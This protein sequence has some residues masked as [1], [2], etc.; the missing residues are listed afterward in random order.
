MFPKGSKKKTKL[1][2]MLRLRAPDCIKHACFGFPLQEDQEEEEPAVPQLHDREIQS[3]SGPAVPREPGLL[4][5]GADLVGDLAVI[6][7]LGT[8]CSCCG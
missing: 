3:A 5:G 2:S 8:R 6:R 1:S 4:P 7:A